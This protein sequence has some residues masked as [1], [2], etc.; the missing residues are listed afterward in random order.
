MPPLLL[1]TW[2]ILLRT[3]LGLMLILLC[4]WL[5]QQPLLLILLAGLCTPV[6]CR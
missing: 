1:G 5:R 3:W 4:T 2:L 6:A